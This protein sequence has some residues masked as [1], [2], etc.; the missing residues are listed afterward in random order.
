MISLMQQYR[1]MLAPLVTMIAALFLLAAIFIPIHN[2]QSKYNEI[3]QKTQPRIER[4]QGMI[5]A[6]PMIEANLQ[7]A[8]NIIRTQL[9]PNTID[10]NRLNTELQ[11]RLRDL[12]QQSGMTVGS[13]RPLPSRK[14]HGLDIFMLNLSLQ[15]GLPELQKFLQGIQR[16]TETTPALRIETLTLRR[17]DFRPN[18]LQTLGIDISI[19]ALRPASTQTPSP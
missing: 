16:P 2:K 12:A 19:A 17:S 1:A 7:E 15:G 9:Y 18:A 4:T 3:I 14:E 8:R 10:D 13:I 5:A 6:A 11:T